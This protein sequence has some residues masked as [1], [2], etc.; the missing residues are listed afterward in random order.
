MNALFT[1]RSRPLGQDCRGDS[2]ARTKLS[3][4]LGPDWLGPLH[5]VFENLIDD[6]F[7]KDA[8]IAVGLKIFLQRFQLE[9]ALVGHVSNFE[10]SEVGQPGFWT[11]RGELGIVDHDFVSGKLVGPGFDLG[12]LR[13]ETSGCVFGRVARR[14]GHGVIVSAPVNAAEAWGK[15]SNEYRGGER[16]PVLAPLLRW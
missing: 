2:A 6:V 13:V 4:D 14:F 8:E 15:A 16:F 5:D 9:A 10:H 1:T 11:N 7:L 12:K 3:V